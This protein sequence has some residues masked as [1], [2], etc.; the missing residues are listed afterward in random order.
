MENRI[1]SAAFIKGMFV[2]AG[3]CVLGYCLY[4]GIV[5]FKTIDRSVSVKG[6]SEREIPADV[7]IWPIK[8]SEA[9]NDL[10]ELYA[11]IE[12]K[13]LAII[14]F[15]KQKGFVDEEITRSAPSITDRQVEYSDAQAQRLRYTGTATITVYTKKVDAV[16]TAAQGMVELGR[17]GIVLAGEDYDSKTEF[18][19][20]RLNEL[21]PAMIEEATRSARE[22]ATKFAKD[23][24]SRLGKIKS[25]AQ[26]QF[27]I[28]DRDSTTPFIKKIRVVSTVEY[29]LVD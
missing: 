1:A 2:C 7:A 19:F 5:Y 3:L 15:L 24:D 18:I 25:A 11:A 26:G 14:D 16:R 12:A 17:Q 13:S 6:L 23:S 29:Y 22:V 21:K 4:A 28:E 9:G 20:N 27:S 8:F 10:N